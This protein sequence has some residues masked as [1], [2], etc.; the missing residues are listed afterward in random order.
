MKIHLLSGFLGSGK[1]TAIQTVCRALAENRTGTAVI[2]NDQGVRLVDGD[3]FRH[4]GIP[5]RQ[6]MNGCFC[7][8][9][10]DLDQ[11]IQ[12]L[13]DTVN[14]AQIFAESVG[15]CTD[16][17]ATVLKPLRR[18]RQDAVVTLSVFAD[19][20]LLHMLLVKGEELFDETVRYIYFKQLEEA[21]ILV[22]NK[23]DLLNPC[24]LEALRKVLQNKF[25]GRLLHF[26]D[27]RD[28]G[29]VAKW[30]ELCDRMPSGPVPESLELNYQIYGEG[31]A[32]LAWLDQ[33]IE[34]ES[35]DNE[36][37]RAAAR[38]ML[39]IHRRIVD[40]R[41][42]IGHLKF[43]LNGKEKFSF[44]SSTTAEL[45]SIEQPA[46]SATL[47][48]NARVQTGPEMLYRLVSLAIAGLENEGGLQIR[49]KSVSS[50]Q[51]G[52]PKPAHRMV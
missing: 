45:K 14:P 6:V 41:Y 34:I 1:T 7:C 4:L 42:P 50:F 46:S 39:D 9:Y 8:N 20:M 51:P 18:F 26:Q 23:A 32:K 2:S 33:E 17:I 25:P 52:F 19:A 30:M 49:T 15:S 40:V 16:I 29:Q 10:E 22:V 35:A 12:S 3:L 38:L 37:N 21:T 31:E 13:K 5:A 11:Q 44:T 28:P 27:A 36:A 47:L 24:Q 43:L 48:L